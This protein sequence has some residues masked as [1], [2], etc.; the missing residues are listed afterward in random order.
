MLFAELSKTSYNSKAALWEERWG[1]AGTVLRMTGGR[2]LF[3]TYQITLLLPGLPWHFII[4]TLS[5]KDADINSH[6][7]SWFPSN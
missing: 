1:R 7:M 4:P 2:L 5:W 6:L 3:G